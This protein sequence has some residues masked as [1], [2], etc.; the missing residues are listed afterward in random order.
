M[1]LEQSQNLLYVHPNAENRS[2]Q[3]YPSLPKPPSPENRRRKVIKSPVTQSYIARLCW[4]LVCGCNTGPRR[5]KSCWIL[6][7]TQVSKSVRIFTEGARIT[8]TPQR[9]RIVLITVRKKCFQSSLKRVQWK[10]L[11]LLT[12]LLL[13]S[14]PW[15]TCWTPGQTFPFLPDW[16]YRL[17]DHLMFLFC[18]TAGFVC[19][20]CQTKSAPSRFLNALKIT[21]LSFIHSFNV[22]KETD[23]SNNSRTWLTAYTKLQS[24]E[25]RLSLRSQCV[26]H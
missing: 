23:R 13:G 26:M 19:M 12:V 6:Y 9:R 25:V 7:I 20:V 4:N 14:L 11:L 2:G 3:N 18:S 16:F 22:Y 21:V 15:Q 17:S 10:R 8:E 24:T 5:L 1:S